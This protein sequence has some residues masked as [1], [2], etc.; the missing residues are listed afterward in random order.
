MFVA[1]R[2]I[3]AAKGR[4]ALLGGVIV[5]LTVLLIMLTGLTEGL[6]KR[7]TSALESLDPAAVY[8][9]TEEPDFT[10]SLI[11]E[12]TADS[13][14]AADA[15]VLGVSQL[16][17]YALLGLPEGM[18]IPGTE[19]QVPAT[20]VIA[21]QSIAEDARTELDITIT[22]EVPDLYYSHVPVLWMSQ[23]SWQELAPVPPSTQG[24]VLLYEDDAAADAAA[25]YLANNSGTEGT[26][27]SLRDSLNGLPAYNSERSSLLT[28][29]G[30]L[31]GIAAL[32]T[33]AFLTVWTVQRTRDLAILRALGASGGYLRRDALGQAAMILAVA[34]A[35]GALVGAGL[36]WLA[37]QAVPFEFNAVVIAGPALGIFLLGILGALLATRGV[38][39]T[40]PLLALGGNA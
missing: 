28:M 12:H 32:V 14:L 31:Y 13:P 29:Q 18:T 21:S 35:C 36:G 2:E 34:G 3:R 17:G 25:D 37:S 5:L 20:G 10:R 4:F 22:D 11:N 38:A 27:V 33:V 16:R 30:F 26:V 6:G 1:L 9:A 8:F 39:K 19:V 7:N 23:Q 24:T 40:N 15:T